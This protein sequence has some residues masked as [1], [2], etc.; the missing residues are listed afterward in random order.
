MIVLI[1]WV[2]VLKI[3]EVFTVEQLK[4]KQ[5]RR[6]FSDSFEAN[7]NGGSFLNQFTGIVY[8]YLTSFDVETNN[9]ICSRW[10]V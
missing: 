7:G 5:E 1:I 3:S 10:S 2:V 6:A 8:A 9:A 4:E